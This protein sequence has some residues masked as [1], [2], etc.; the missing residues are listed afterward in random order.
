M[1]IRNKLLLVLLSF[2]LSV[3]SQ[4]EFSGDL[5]LKV[6]YSEN[7]DIPFW[8]YN[9]QQGRI[10]KNTDISSWI[11]G[12]G[13]YKM[14]SHSFIEI[15]GGLLYRNGGSERISI[16]ELYAQYSNSW[17]QLSLGVK[18][19]EALYGGLSAANENILWTLNAR[20][21]PGIQLRTAEP[22]YFTS[23]K[24]WAFDAEWEEYLMGNKRY[25]KNT[26][27]HHKSF[28]LLYETSTGWQIKAGIQ[29]F[30]QWAGTS[31]EYGTQP[32]S[33]KD[34]LKIITGR[35]G[36]EDAT[37]SD[38]QNALGNHLGSYELS[39]KKKIALSEVGFIYN[40][41]FEDGSGSRF[42]NFP[43][44]RYGIY[45]KRQKGVFVNNLIYEF[46]YTKDQSHDV[47]KWGADNY[48]GHTI[49]YNSGWTYLDRII[50]TPFFEYNPDRHMMKNNKFIAH[51]LGMSGNYKIL[52][53]RVPYKFMLTYLVNEGT[54]RNPYFSKHYK[55]YTYFS[56]R[57]L[58]DPFELSIE[59]GS[60][61]DSL[62]SPV[63]GIGLNL[64]KT[65]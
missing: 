41:I 39:V 29:H 16:D 26:H 6:F 13:V 40:S 4:L 37:L 19:K 52:N 53:N 3:F 62:N 36:G 7:K 48:F 24:K 32:H 42:A 27:L 33:I 51:H 17:L 38:K 8:F 20:P 55:F 2:P 44:G 65:F 34:Y 58:K 9:S 47:N 11:S 12:I 28:H 30:V 49:L 23:N 46:Y 56:S 22:I 43:D 31:P 1:K 54:Y 61:F 35:G 18:Q 63:Y 14:N 21:L 57:I 50:G 45:W 59:L 5:N 15:G 60:D 64:T 25:V 10:S